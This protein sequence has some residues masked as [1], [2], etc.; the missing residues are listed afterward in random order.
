MV[1][2]PEEYKWSSYSMYIGNE[3]II[4]S[5]KILS[6]FKNNSREK[7]KD[8]IESELKLMEGVAQ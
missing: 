4:S 1:T 3:K 6:Y 5:F 8:Y 7:Y 2:H